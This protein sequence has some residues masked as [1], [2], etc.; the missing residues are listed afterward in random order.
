MVSKILENKNIWG[1][2]NKDSIYIPSLSILSSDIGWPAKA[3]LMLLLSSPVTGTGAG[4]SS[5][6]IGR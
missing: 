2:N 4:N 1:K 6:M 5:D 3:Y